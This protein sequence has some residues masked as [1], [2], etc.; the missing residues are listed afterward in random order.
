MTSHL[1][2]YKTGTTIAA[3]RLP[4]LEMTCAS[5]SDKLYFADSKFTV[6]DMQVLD[7]YENVP[8]QVRAQD[9]FQEY[10]RL[11]AS[12]S[13]HIPRGGRHFWLLARYLDPYLLAET[14]K[15]YRDKDW[16]VVVDDDTFVN[17]HT[18]LR[19]LKHFDP[20]E[21]YWFGTPFGH[22]RVPFAHGGGGFVLSQRRMR[23]TFGSDPDYASRNVEA[24]TTHNAGDLNLGRLFRDDENVKI[25]GVY[26]GFPS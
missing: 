12:V 4:I 9:S 18:L 25:K 11:Q 26:G 5:P 3:A 13:S 15:R 6:G 19:W 7:A 10:F 14:Y 23:D 21:H 8:E 16:Y 20:S 2:V 17:W 22:M 1:A 24:Y